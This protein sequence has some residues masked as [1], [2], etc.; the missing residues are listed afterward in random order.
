[1]CQIKLSTA[2]WLGYK[3]SPAK[4]WKDPRVNAHWAAKYLR[5]QIKRYKGDILCG[6]SAYNAGSCHKAAGKIRNTNYI[7][8]VFKSWIER[9]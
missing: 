1:M 3:G 7:K 8:L 9:K 5:Y 4:L 6:V 2:R